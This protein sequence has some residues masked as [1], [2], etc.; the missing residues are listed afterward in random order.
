MVEKFRKAFTN[1]TAKTNCVGKNQSG[2]M[3]LSAL[4]E[5]PVILMLLEVTANAKEKI[6]TLIDLASDTNYITHKAAR[7]LNLRSEKMTL[8]VHGVGGMNMNVKTRRYF[9]R[10]RIKM[11]TDTERAHEL[12]CYGLDEIA[13]VH[14]PEQFKKFFPEVK[15]ED[16]KRPKT[17]ELL[18]SHRE[19]RLA[20]WVIGDLVLW[21]GPLGKTVGGAHPDLFEKIDMAMHKSETHFAR[22]MRAS[23]L[24]YQ[25]I[26]EAQEFKAETKVAG[27]EF[28]EWWKWDS[29]GAACEPKCGGCRC[30]NC[31]PR[32]K[33]MTLSEE[34]E[35]EVIKKGLIYVRA[36]EHS[37][38]PH[39]DTKYP[40]I[41]DPISLPNNRS[42]V[43]TTFFKD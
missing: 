8:I 9:L 2:V 25:E 39:W 32:G 3:E 15:L 43:E 11:H 41:E 35:L 10:V 14:R 42:G 4:E 21:E 27:K 28:L 24:R 20:N 36:D 1:S 40:W 16:L 17:I 29:I 7:R 22:S 12:V 5:L 23:A 31:Q 37:D 6:G 18:I 30:G 34:R 19:G 33:E 38:Q 26:T 13:K